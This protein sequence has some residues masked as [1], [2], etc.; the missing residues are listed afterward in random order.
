MNTKK[1]SLRAKRAIGIM[2]L[3]VLLISM[4]GTVT[5]FAATAT[6]VTTAENTISAADL[7]ARQQAAAQA[8]AT[9]TVYDDTGNV[10]AGP[11]IADIINAMHNSST[12]N[13]GVRD[14]YISA[15]GV[16][17]STGVTVKDINKQI[18]QI[19]DLTNIT[20]DTNAGAGLMSPE[21][22]SLIS[23][24]LGAIVIVVLM[25]VGFFTGLDIMF[26]EIPLFHS[27]LENNAMSKGTT[28]KNGEP[29][30]RCVS[31]D[32]I[33]AYK[34]AA[35][36]GKNVLIVYLKKRIVAIVAVSIVIFMLLS[37]NLTGIVKIVLNII[38]KALEFINGLGA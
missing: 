34:E 19:A 11:S 13:D 8:V 9:M 7:P 25:A 10:I 15:L 22:Q 37:G 30:P 14:A 20:A 18:D 23:T 2:L 36:I 27:K 33:D 32:A 31:D 29:K 3:I 5:A 26:L 35:E 12:L 21:L 1:K 17:G 24:L 4:L 16:S 28:G 38:S 6:E